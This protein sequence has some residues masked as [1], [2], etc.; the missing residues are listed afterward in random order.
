MSQENQQ[1]NESPI[2]ESASIPFEKWHGTGNDF[3]LCME[4]TALEI[5]PDLSDLA[6]RMCDRHFGVGSDGLI[7][8]G[9]SHVADFGMRMFNP[10]GSEAEM[11]GNGLRCLGGSVLRENV[12]A[13]SEKIN[14]ETMNRIIG[15]DYPDPPSWADSGHVW[16]RVEMGEPVLERFE[17]PIAGDGPSPVIN[18]PLEIPGYGVKV[19]YTAVNFGN[20]HAVIFTDDVDSVPL[21]KWGPAIENHTQLFP[22]RINVEF[23]QVIDGGYVRMRVWERGAGITLSCGS[24]TSA[25]QVACKLTGSAGG[26]LRVDVPGGSLMTEYGDD[27]VLYLSGPAVKTFTGIWWEM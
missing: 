23:V 22:K 27:G 17:I 6:R 9:H 10:D 5:C 14:I 13:R 15:L 11:C 18:E 4:D 3:I 1:N 19:E 25:V 12:V 8:I 21:E 7:L 16:V 20:P 2:D 26:K 24:G